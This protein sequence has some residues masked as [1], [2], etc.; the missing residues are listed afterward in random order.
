MGDFEDDL[1]WDTFTLRYSVTGPLSTMLEQSMTKYQQLFKPLWRMKHLEL[2]L[3]ARVWKEQMCQAKLLRSM[4][5]ELAAT[6]KRLHLV[7]HQMVHF[8]HQMLYYILFEVIECQWTT[9]LS[10][11]RK[12][13]TLDD[14]FEAHDLFLREVRRDAFLENDDEI[15]LRMSSVFNAIGKLEGWQYRWYELC[16]A[17]LEARRRLAE[18]VRTS[19]RRGEFG[20]TGERQAERDAEHKAFRFSLVQMH[21]ELDKIGVD[22]EMCVRK[23]LLLLA[24]SADANIQLFGTRLDFNEYYKRRD[25][26]LDVPLTF[27]T[28]RQ[29]MM[30]TSKNGMSWS[31][32]SAAFGN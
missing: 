20:V 16:G 1:G 13:R 28:L 31:G 21:E 17:E 8:I 23:F 18:E 9:M 11:V 14:I 30:Y 12:A 5:R 15:Y 7:T 29:S 3:C 19:E 10:G 4:H 27:A 25:E 2:V 26:Q 24:C 32:G 6:A 22:Y